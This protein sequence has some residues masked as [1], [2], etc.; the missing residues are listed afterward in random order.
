MGKKARRANVGA[1]LERSQGR[2]R[3]SGTRQ[4]YRPGTLCHTETRRA[5]RALWA[6]KVPNYD[7][8]GEKD[9]KLRLT[10]TGPSKSAKIGLETGS[11]RRKGT[12][13]KGEG[14]ARTNFQGESRTSTPVD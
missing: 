4:K 3:K 12:K 13:P 7:P 5:G 2:L 14:V 10:E 6:E 1:P 9:I 8:R 11:K